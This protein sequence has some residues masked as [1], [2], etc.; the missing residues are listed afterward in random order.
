MRYLRIILVLAV[1]LTFSSGPINYAQSDSH[2]F[3][4]TGHTVQGVFWQYWEAHGG[5]AQQGYP[6]SDELRERSDLN[7]QMYT[8]QYFE[9][10]VFERH[11]EN[12]PPFDVLLSQLGTF[13]Y[14]QKYPTGAF[15]QHAN[16]QNGRY[17]SE[18]GHTVGGAF[19]AYWEQHGGLAQQ[20]FPISEEFSERS[21]L[22]GQTYTVQYFER[23]VFEFH[24]E[25]QQPFDVLL[26]QLGKFQ[27][28]HK[29]APPTPGPILTGQEFGIQESHV[30]WQNQTLDSI[31][32]QLDH[33]ASGGLHW[34]RFDLAWMDAEPTPGQWSSSYLGWLDSVLS[35][36]QERGINPIAILQTAPSWAKTTRTGCW[37]DDH[38]GDRRE[39]AIPPNNPADYGQAAG[40]LAQRYAGRI[41]V[42]E[43]WNEP[44]ICAFWNSPSGPDP[45]AYTALLHAGYAAIKAAAP[46][47]VVLGGALSGNDEAFVRGMYAAGAKADFDALSVHPYSNPNGP[48]WIG[49]GHELYSFADLPNMKQVMEAQGDPNKPIWITEV[50]WQLSDQVNDATRAGFLRQAVAMVR[51]WPY[52][53]MMIV[54][55]LDS[56]GEGPPDDRYTLWVNGNPTQAWTAYTQA[57][58]S[59]P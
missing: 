52:V 25:N 15:S 27:W 33:V 41:R 53:K 56:F 57:V 14:H 51:T 13:R 9:R 18:T 24:P 20:G 32:T 21:D 11:P 22:N 7:G 34:L 26:S 44:N 58:A 23:A 19:R 35:M 16:T 46:D 59:H 48:D 6:I 30:L 47:D 10:A 55:S 12:Q 1:L 28:D 29:H 39:W 45:T 40:Y 43:I 8:V 50:G 4:E 37:E 36:M 42:W 38:N 31:R 5:L 2:Y 49:S 54:F 3:S 17:Y